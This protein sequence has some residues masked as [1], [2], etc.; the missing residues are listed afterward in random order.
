MF[1]FVGLFNGRLKC[2]LLTGF[3]PTN[4]LFSLLF[5]SCEY[6]HFQLQLVTCTVCAH[7]DHATLQT[8]LQSVDSFKNR[9][10]KIIV[11]LQFNDGFQKC[12][13]SFEA[14]EILYGK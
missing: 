9:A 5:G 7:H 13:N 8:Q 1:V 6:V 2:D 12:T 11:T 3:F 14:D 4:L 10:T